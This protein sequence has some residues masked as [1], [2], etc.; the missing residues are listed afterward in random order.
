MCVLHLLW[1]QV[2]AWRRLEHC[3]NSSTVSSQKIYSQL[4]CCHSESFV[5]RP[6]PS[7]SFCNPANRL[8]HRHGWKH[9]LHPNQLL[10]IRSRSVGYE[11]YEWVHV[12]IVLYMYL[13]HSREL[14]LCMYTTVDNY[15][16]VCISQ[17]RIIPVYL[18]HSSELYLC[19]YT[20]VE[21]YTYVCIPQ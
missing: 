10:A 7:I 21:N 12:C 20:T 8:T 16:Y 3:G 14:Y 11:F 9:S 15:T 19:I 13:Y 5:T 2:S 18:Y 17:W 1:L 6:N 4:F